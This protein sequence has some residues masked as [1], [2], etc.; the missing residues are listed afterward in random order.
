VTRLCRSKFFPKSTPR[1]RRTPH[2]RLTQPT[3]TA[4]RP[5]P[6][7]PSL[8]PT[9]PTRLLCPLTAPPNPT[10][11]QPGPTV[12][13]PDLTAVVP[14]PTTV[15]PARFARPQHRLAELSPPTVPGHHTAPGYN[16]HAGGHRPLPTPAPV[17]GR[18]PRLTSLSLIVARHPPLVGDRRM[19]VARLRLPS[20]TASVT[21]GGDGDIR[22]DRRLVKKGR[23]GVARSDSGSS[24]LGF[25]PLGGS[26]PWPPGGL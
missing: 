10:V 3:T 25:G 24:A 12:T 5:L 18:Q 1:P 21:S 6:H 17:G 9:A 22:W 2:R 11:T 20:S 19:V 23:G 13:P 7:W 4:S 14:A 15:P 16:A 8:T 26:R